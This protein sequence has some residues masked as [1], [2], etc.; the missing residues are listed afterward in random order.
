M[1]HSFINVK[2][3]SGELKRTEIRRGVGYRLTDK[4]FILMREEASYHILLEDI[5]GVTLRDEV[6]QILSPVQVGD[7]TFTHAWGGAES[8]KI[9]AMKMRVY[10]RSGVYERGAS[11]LYTSLS[12]G[13]S[14]QMHELLLAT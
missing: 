14:R 1:K 5:L 10:N 2:S 12:S 3:M 8:Y 9:V 4:E 11:T 7:A 13:F 6:D